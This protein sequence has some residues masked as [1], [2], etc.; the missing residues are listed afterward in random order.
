FSLALGGYG[1]FGIILDA[2]LHVVANEKYRVERLSVSTVDYAKALT[3]K[4]NQASDNVMVYGRLRVTAGRFLQDGIIKFFHRIPATNVVISK[5][6]PPQN[7]IWQRAVFRGSAGD[8]YGK[9][10]RWSAEQNFETYLLG[11]IFDRNDVLY[12]P[13]ALFQDRRKESV[14]ILME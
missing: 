13:A 4:T 2:D 5:L 12:D 1:L 6:D 9:E 11:E 3:E 7:A 10:L 8:D 14:D